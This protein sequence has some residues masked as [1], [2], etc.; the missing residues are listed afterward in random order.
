MTRPLF[1]AV[2]V[3]MLF[4][5]ATPSAAVT[6]QDQCPGVF[7]QCYTIPPDRYPDGCHP[8]GWTLKGGPRGDDISGTSRRD[9]LLGGRG[10]DGLLG[11]EQRDCLFGQR[12]VDNIDGRRGNDWIRGGKGV[13]VLDGGTGNDLLEGGPGED[14]SIEGFGGRDLIYGGPGSD[15]RRKVTEVGHRVRY[16][17]AI[18][19]GSGRDRIVDTKGHNDI[20][21][22][23]G[24]DTVVTNRRSHVE[25]CERVTR[26]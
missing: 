2:A 16:V 10:A 3:V 4:A 21:C 20:D 22:G 14:F 1:S 17:A 15:H 23:K 24:I 7:A 18:L 6:G 26:R 8:N 12:G 19:G 9:L 13:D 11:Y 25:K 5:A